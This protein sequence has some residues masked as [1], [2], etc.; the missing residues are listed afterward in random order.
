M[1]LN[2]L[3]RPDIARVAIVYAATLSALAL[4]GTVLAYWTWMAFAPRAEPRLSPAAEAATRAASAQGLFGGSPR[5][6]AATAPAGRA[7]RLFGIVAATGDHPGYAVVRLEARSSLA[8]RVGENI[9]PGIRLVEVHPDH[10]VLDRNGARETL[11][12]PRKESS[13]VNR[14]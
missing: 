9:A 2:A 4:L 6:R 5:D 7:I 3:G 8:V 13:A 12:W 14:K 11:D 10:V 1:K